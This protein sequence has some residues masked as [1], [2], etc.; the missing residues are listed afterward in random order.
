MI[1]DSL[2]LD[3]ADLDLNE[4]FP[5]KNVSTRD[6]KT[7]PEPLK[8]AV[9]RFPVSINFP[10]TFPLNGNVFCPLLTAVNGHILNAIYCHC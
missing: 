1:N 9:Y 6:V 3:L 8:T 7:G 5:S 10:S 4:L 2:F